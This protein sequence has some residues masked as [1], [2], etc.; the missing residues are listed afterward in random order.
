[1]MRLAK[2]VLVFRCLVYI[3]HDIKTEYQGL[4]QLKQYSGVL[5]LTGNLEELKM[6]LVLV[7][8]A[9]GQ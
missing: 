3:S 8:V 7:A 9:T 5:N 4:T 2:L 6:T 1:M